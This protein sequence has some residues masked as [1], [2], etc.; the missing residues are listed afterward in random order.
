MC[1]RIHPLVCAGS[2]DVRTGRVVSGNQDRVVAEALR[3]ARDDTEFVR[4][5]VHRIELDATLRQRFMDDMRAVEARLGDPRL[6]LAFVG[7]FDSGKSTFI[8]ALLRDELLPAQLARATDVPVEVEHGRALQVLVRFVGGADWHALPGEERIVGQHLGS[9]ALAFAEGDVREWLQVLAAGGTGSCVAGLKV[10]YPALGLQQVVYIDTPGT[11]ASE[12]HTELTRQVLTQRADMAVIVVSSDNPLPN[13]LVD[14]LRDGIEPQV[15]RRCLVVVTKITH[16]RPVERERLLRAVGDRLWRKLGEAV[17]PVVPASGR[18]LLDRLAGE[19][20]TDDERHWSDRFEQLELQ[21]LE[22]LRQQRAVIIAD[23]V[24]RLL[25]IVLTAVSREVEAA[26]VSVAARQAQL[27]AAVVQN[28]DAFLAKRVEAGRQ[29]LIILASEL[30]E[31]ER[32]RRKR[33]R[34]KTRAA[35]WH[36]IDAARDVRVLE[37]VLDH[38]VEAA[39]E[40]AAKRVAAGLERCRDRLQTQYESVADELEREFHR[41]YAQL[42]D[43]AR[44]PLPE[45]IGSGQID[46]LIVD[47]DVPMADAHAAIWQASTGSLWRTGGAAATGTFV[48]MLAGPLGAVAGALAGSFVGWLLSPT[49]DQTRETVK[50]QLGP[51]IGDFFQELGHDARRLVVEMRSGYEEALGH[52]A[53]EYLRRYR[54]AVQTLVD[55]QQRAAHVLTEQRT[56]LEREGAELTRRIEQLRSRREELMS[57]LERFPLPA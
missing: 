37:A 27:D 53:A 26:R 48:G 17:I 32:R 33:I 8:N 14:F 13:S 6:Y 50:E 3:D 54:R 42:E 57:L 29:Q 35:L 31:E 4:N 45:A 9:A 18:A 38:E 30:G 15:L 47:S 11:D 22:R 51:P 39:L 40:D 49:I 43:V 5:L 7:E 52:L 16:V 44:K 25:H 19:L 12:A 24:L 1:S 28:L 55:D 56:L 21:L 34:R 2:Q 10:R 23:T 36:E 41:A 46:D 20:L